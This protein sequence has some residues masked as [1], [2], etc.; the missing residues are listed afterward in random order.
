MSVYGVFAWKREQNPSSDRVP[1][2][3]C[4]LK[5]L[6]DVEKSL[7][8]V[9]RSDKAGLAVDDLIS[10]DRPGRRRRLILRQEAVVIV[11]WVSG[12][13]AV[14]E[15]LGKRHRVFEVAYIESALYGHGRNR[16]CCNGN[17]VEE[18]RCGRLED[19]ILH[20]YLH[21]SAVSFVSFFLF[22][23]LHFL[24]ISHLV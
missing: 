4:S 16:V 23:F 9:I 10:V 2:F 20:S 15:K 8:K 24:F 11:S 6:F 18:P 1:M 19:Q 14:W 3:F 22:Y 5:T 13:D 12:L 21:S 7:G 17:P